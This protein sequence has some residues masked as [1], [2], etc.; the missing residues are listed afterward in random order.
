M[1]AVERDKESENRGE[2]NLPLRKNRAVEIE[3]IKLI[4]DNVEG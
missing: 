4:N 1:N 2:R 3:E